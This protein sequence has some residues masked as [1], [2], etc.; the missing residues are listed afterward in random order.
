MDKMHNF[1]PIGQMVAVD[2]FE[3]LCAP[4]FNAIEG[5]LKSRNARG[6]EEGLQD[7][8]ATLHPDLCAFIQTQSMELGRVPPEFLLTIARAFP[9]GDARAALRGLDVR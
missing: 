7:D 5:I 9:R 1:R 3:Q 2:L 6:E 8:P 4:G